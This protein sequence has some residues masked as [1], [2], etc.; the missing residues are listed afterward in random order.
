MAIY[1]KKKLATKKKSKNRESN[2]IRKF[3]PVL[4]RNLPKEPFESRTLF[5]QVVFLMN[6]K[7]TNVPKSGHCP[8]SQSIERKT[9]DFKSRTYF[10]DFREIS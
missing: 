4:P 10:F 6:R 9:T 8:H 5:C 3:Y 2:P 1:R 7:E